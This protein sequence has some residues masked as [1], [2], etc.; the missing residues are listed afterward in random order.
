MMLF[1]LRARLPHCCAAARVL[2]TRKEEAFRARQKIGQYSLRS[3]RCGLYR[4]SALRIHGHRI[5]RRI[6]LL[7]RCSVRDRAKA[8][9]E[10]S[11]ELRSRS[12][13]AG[14][15]LAANFH[16]C[17]DNGP[18]SDIN[19]S[20]HASFRHSKAAVLLPWQ[21]PRQASGYAGKCLLLAR[22]RRHSKTQAPLRCES[23]A[24]KPQP[25]DR[26]NPHPIQ[27]P[28]DP[29]TPP[30][31]RHAPPLRLPRSRVL[32]SSRAAT[33]NLA[34]YRPSASFRSRSSPEF[35][36]KCPELAWFS[37][38]RSNRSSMQET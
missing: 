35:P 6:D 7:L 2:L 22:L 9:R 29:E 28:R 10:G 16:T 8:F 15:L 30:P 34:M 3:Y 27:G 4:D 18:K 33:L 36:A 1:R 31:S 38:P 32:P 5:V 25:A 17:A 19:A 37:L 11:A 13:K 12:A 21:L 20:R 26:Q 23:L 14:R 24:A